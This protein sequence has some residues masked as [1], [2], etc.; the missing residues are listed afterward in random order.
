LRSVRFVGL[1][2]IIISQCTVQKQFYS[3]FAYIRACSANVDRSAVGST[4]QRRNIFFR[5]SLTLYY[6][7]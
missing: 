7:S 5:M 4:V 3:I 1:R 2:Y 6:Q